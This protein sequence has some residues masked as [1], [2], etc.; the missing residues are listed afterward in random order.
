MPGSPVQLAMVRRW[1]HAFLELD[2]VA[3]ETVEVVVLLASE[4]VAN[5]VAHSCSREGEVTVLLTLDPECGR[6]RLDV[7]DDGPAVAVT[8][9]LGSVEHEHGRGLLLVD[10]LSDLWGCYPDEHGT[11]VWFEVAVPDQSSCPVTVVRDE[12]G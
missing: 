6:V 3:T 1:V 5:A 10:E 11:V 8:A 2:K 9:G 4:L 12:C 7:I